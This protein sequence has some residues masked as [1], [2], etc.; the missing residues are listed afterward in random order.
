[1]NDCGWTALLMAAE[2]LETVT[3]TPR[4][5]AISDTQGSPKSITAL[6]KNTDDCSL[7]AVT[8]YVVDRLYAE[9]TRFV[10][11]QKN[12]D[13]KL[14]SNYYSFLLQYSKMRIYV[15]GKIGVKK[16]KLHNQSYFNG[17]HRQFYQFYHS[18]A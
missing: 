10:S 12:P 17:H 15:P 6:Q 5:S 14:N 13:D 2:L 4:Q 18:K 9:S 16:A 3:V 8:P 7:L 1:M 11:H